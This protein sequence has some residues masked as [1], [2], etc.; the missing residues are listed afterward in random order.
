MK[1]LVYMIINIYLKV[2]EK[3]DWKFD[4]T[5]VAF[6]INLL[7]HSLVLQLTTV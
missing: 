6:K 4:N 7:F 5:V 3:I 2:L 1:N